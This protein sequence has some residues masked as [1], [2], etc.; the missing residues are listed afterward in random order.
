M[1]ILVET[2]VQCPHCGEIY[3]TMVDTS[4]GDQSTIEDC[5]VCCRPIQLEICCTPGEV[6]SVEAA[7]G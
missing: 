3:P 4:Q 6:I 1:D 5:P 2:E 7:A